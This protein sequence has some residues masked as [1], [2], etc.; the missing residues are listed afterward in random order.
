MKKQIIAAITTHPVRAAFLLILLFLLGSVMHQA[1]GQGN[2]SNRSVAANI[3]QVAP[4]SS[5]AVSAP[6]GVPATPT[7]PQI[8]AI[9]KSQLPTNGVALPGPSEPT[10]PSPW[11]L[12]TPYPTTI[13][14]YGFAQT[15]THL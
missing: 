6:P 15:T 14:R 11:T 4:D 1:L 2:A 7:S 5:G 9:P 10:I 12:G 3:S 8:P 13:V